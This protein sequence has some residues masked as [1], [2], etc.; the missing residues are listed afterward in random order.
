[1]RWCLVRPLNEAPDHSTDDKIERQRQTEHEQD[2][3]RGDAQTAERSPELQTGE[4]IS[5]LSGKSAQ[6][7]C[8]AAAWEAAEIGGASKKNVPHFVLRA[9][10]GA[11][12]AEWAT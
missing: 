11:T 8:H 1:M 9:A 5:R 3:T 2:Q 4:A 10:M 12:Q 7:G 6:R